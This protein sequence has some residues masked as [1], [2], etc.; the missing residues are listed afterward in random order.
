M[1]KSIRKV[2]LA[3]SGGLD[4]SVILRWIKEE[5]GAEVITYT[6][7]V[8]QGEE[9]EEARVKALATGASQAICEDLT[10][11]FVS[12]YVFPAFRA[13]ALYEGYYHMGT[14]LSRPVIS[15]GLVRAAVETGADA[16]AHGATGKGNDQ[17]RFELSAYALKP[18]IKVI[19]PWREW[20]FKGRADLVAYAEEH[21]IYIASLGSGSSRREKIVSAY[22][23]ISAHERNLANRFL[24]GVESLPHVTLYG[25]PTATGRS[26]TFAV[27]V[28]G[29]SS[30]TVAER[31]GERGCFV[32]AGDYYAYEV[33][34]R[35]DRGAAGLVRIG[36]V[37]Y[38]TEDEV[39]RVLG[40]LDRLA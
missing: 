26:A 8:G 39:E 32:W 10:A 16:I 31:L 17:V 6:A 35:L 34:H 23:A 19:A 24:A 37:H 2:V 25:Q 3:Y 7:D 29:I 4:T 27:E 11:E 9:T 14:S 40:E 21:G 18:D 15:K 5:Y 1:D 33:M 36:F 13:S 28:D 20:E 38:N 30:D 22:S 12:D